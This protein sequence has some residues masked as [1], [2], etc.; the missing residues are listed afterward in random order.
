MQYVLG[1]DRLVQHLA[2]EH[3]P[4]PVEEFAQRLERCETSNVIS[5]QLRDR[6]L[7]GRIDPESGGLPLTTVCSQIVDVGHPAEGW[8]FN[9]ASGARASGPWTA[10]F[11]VD[12]PV[13]ISVAGARDM[14]T[15]VSKPVRVSGGLTVAE[16]GSVT[17]LVVDGVEA[18]PD[19]VGR[20]AWQ[21][22]PRDYTDEAWL[23][24]FSDDAL[25]MIDQ[26]LRGAVSPEESIGR[27]ADGF[28]TPPALMD[29]ITREM[30]D[31]EPPQT[32]GTLQSS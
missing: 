19:D 10:R 25:K 1:L 27:M 6:L 24:P 13:V 5:E 30:G 18:L 21:R 15:D 14:P 4:V 3:A 23:F 28:Q 32:C 31:A 20:A 17:D 2:S 26:M 8:Q 22:V 16:D 7:G 12:V 9:D 29:A 11:R